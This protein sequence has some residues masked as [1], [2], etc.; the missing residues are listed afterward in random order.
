MSITDP[1]EGWHL[2]KAIP[3]SIILFLAAQTI[4]LIIWAVRLDYR[5]TTLET[6]QPLQ[7]AK[8]SNL[9]VLRDRLILIEERQNNVLKALENNAKKLDTVLEQTTRRQQ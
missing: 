7:D 9:E 2:S 8:I 5:V 1:Q 4:G 6:S 3:I